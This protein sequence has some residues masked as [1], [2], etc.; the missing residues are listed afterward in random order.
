M[1]P[2]NLYTLHYREGFGKTQTSIVASNQLMADAVGKKWCNSRVNCRFIRTE[3]AISADETILT[4]AEIAAA[5]PKVKE[6]KADVASVV[7][8]E[9]TKIPDGEKKSV[10]TRA[11]GMAANPGTAKSA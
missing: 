1:D 5:T 7:A 2:R 3:P 6:K 4:E 8:T 9:N 11:A 10:A